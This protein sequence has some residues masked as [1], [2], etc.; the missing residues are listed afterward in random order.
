MRI[1]RPSK[2]KRFNEI[3]GNLFKR[4]PETPEYIKKGGTPRYQP[5]MEAMKMRPA[6]HLHKVFAMKHKHVT[7]FEHGHIGYASDAKTARTLVHQKMA[8]HGIKG[9]KPRSMAKR[10][11]GKHGWE[12]FF[13][14]STSKAHYEETNL[15]PEMLTKMM[16]E[17]L[18]EPEK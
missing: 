18:L 4:K 2:L 13:I 3:F 17:G 10:E 12:G 15:N 1:V 14:P 7:D 11:Y 5:D 16:Q 8:K 6:E 9:S